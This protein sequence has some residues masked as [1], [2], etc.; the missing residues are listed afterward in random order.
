MGI[1]D[2]FLQIYSKEGFQGFKKGILISLV[3]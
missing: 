3:A 1:R 2:A